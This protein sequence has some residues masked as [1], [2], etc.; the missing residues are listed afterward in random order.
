MLRFKALKKWYQRNRIEKCMEETE[1]YKR[2][3]IQ[4]V[5]CFTKKPVRPWIYQICRR[6]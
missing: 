6:G 2:V 1:V 4:S 3:G 5:H